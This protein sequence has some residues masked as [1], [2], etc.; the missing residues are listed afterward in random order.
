MRSSLRFAS[1][2]RAAMKHRGISS[3]LVNRALVIIGY[4]CAER[5]RDAARTAS[6]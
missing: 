6:C 3:E 2:E 5:A 4:A 1:P